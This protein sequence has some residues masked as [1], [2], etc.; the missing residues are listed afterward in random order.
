MTT[1]TTQS[2]RLSAA[3]DDSRAVQSSATF[4]R[5][6]ARL[7]TTISFTAP[8]TISHGGNGFAHFPV[9]AMV[10]VRNSALNARRW[11]VVASTAGALTVT[12]A[13]VRTEA[14]GA[15]ITVRMVD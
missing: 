12:P 4:D 9:G 6:S 1:R 10:E 15:A 5:G 13:R 14:A 11:R 2:F 8:D 3:G 7:A